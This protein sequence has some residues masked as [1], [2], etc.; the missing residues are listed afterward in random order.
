MNYLIVININRTFSTSIQTSKGLFHPHEPK[1][2]YSSTNSSSERLSDQTGKSTVNYYF[3]SACSSQNSD[4][5]EEYEHFNK[6]RYKKMKKE[7]KNISSISSLEHLNGV[8][9]KEKANG[10][11]HPPYNHQISNRSDL[12]LVQEQ[13]CEGTTSNLQTMMHLLKGNI[14]TGKYRIHI[15]FNSN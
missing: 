6:D 1:T 8:K 13:P 15:F 14:G 10:L 3:N 4:N 12:A 5:E 9:S 7:I 2:A 11:V